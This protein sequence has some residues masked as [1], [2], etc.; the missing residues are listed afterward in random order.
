MRART[1][2][3]IILGLAIKEER[4]PQGLSQKQL[5]SMIGTSKAHIWRIENGKIATTIGRLAQ[6]A[7]A[8]E[9]RV[10][11]LIRF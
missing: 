3:K 5:A 11:T 2:P 6:V 8:L 7:E 9:V 10:S 1:D 4:I